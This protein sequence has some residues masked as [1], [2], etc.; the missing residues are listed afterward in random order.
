MSGDFTAEELETLANGIRDLGTIDAR[1]SVLKATLL[2]YPDLGEVATGYLAEVLSDAS[3]L[4][5]AWQELSTT[6]FG[7]LYDPRVTGPDTDE[8]EPE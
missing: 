1:M 8:P 5:V 7:A 3:D 2:R 6:S 4:V